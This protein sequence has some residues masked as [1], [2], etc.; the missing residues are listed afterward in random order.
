MPSYSKEYKDLGNV[1]LDQILGATILSIGTT[2]EEAEEYVTKRGGK[3][4][5]IPSGA[6][7]HPLG[8]L[9]YAQC[10]SVAL[11]GSSRK[12]IVVGLGQG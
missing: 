12:I 6:S 7:A 1:Q 2:Q 8:G 11:Q 10:K 4:Y 9:G 5:W 3:P